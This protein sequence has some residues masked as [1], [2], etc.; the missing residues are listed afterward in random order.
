V[1]WQAAA[2]AWANLL[3]R[4]SFSASMQGL[5]EGA[6]LQA[7]LQGIELPLQAVLSDM[8]VTGVRC[9]KQLLLEQKVQLQVRLG[10]GRWVHV[11]LCL[12]VSLQVSVW[13]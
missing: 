8:E 4:D 9:D 13:A 3:L 12:V 1:V 11:H 2:G 6:Q 10:A 7:L 5:S